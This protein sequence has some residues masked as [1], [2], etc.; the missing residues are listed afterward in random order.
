MKAIKTT[1][2]LSLCLCWWAFMPLCPS[3]C[4]AAA[5][6]KMT[7]QELQSLESNLIRLEQINQQQQ[8]Q[9]KLLQK[10]L[11]LS[12][13]ELAQA[14]AKSKLLQG[15]LKELERQVV[16][17]ERLLENA[18]QSF[19]QY[20]QEEKQKISKLKRQRNLLWLGLGSAILYGIVHK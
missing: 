12:L 4:E 14:E 13:K 2:L 16:T 6:Y 7:E 8:N 9:S 5:A 17:Q 3:Y 10:Q 1:A 15:Q 19:K 20:A 11:D 18:N